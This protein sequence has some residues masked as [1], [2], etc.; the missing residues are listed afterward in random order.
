MK[1]PTRLAL[2]LK[3]R[4]KEITAIDVEPRIYRCYTGYVQKQSG[5]Y[6]WAMYDEDEVLSVVSCAPAAEVARAK[7]LSM[8]NSY[9]DSLTVELIVEGE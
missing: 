1:N 2:K 4:I 6:S 8:Y 3:R 7:N 5:A 9:Y